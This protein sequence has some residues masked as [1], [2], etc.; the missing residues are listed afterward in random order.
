MQSH[1]MKASNSLKIALLLA[2]SV[3]LTVAQVKA[4]DDKSKGQMIDFLRKSRISSQ[5]GSTNSRGKQDDTPEG[6]KGGKTIQP[7]DTKDAEHSTQQIFRDVIRKW[8]QF[9]GVGKPLT[10]EQARHLNCTYTLMFD[11][12]GLCVQMKALDGYG[13]PTTDHRI[14][15][16]LTENSRGDYRVN[17]TIAEQMD[18]VCSWKF[19]YDDKKHLVYEEGYDAGG[20]LVYVMHLNHRENTAFGSYSDFYGSPLQLR[21]DTLQAPPTNF[22]VTYDNEGHDARLETF[23]NNGFPCKNLDGAYSWRRTYDAIG[24]KTSEASC[25]LMGHRTIDDFGNCGFSITYST[26]G[27]VKTY[28]YRDAQWNIMPLPDSISSNH[29]GVVTVKEEYDDYGRLIQ[30]TFYD[31]EQQET[32][33]KR[34]FNKIHYEYNPHGL[35]RWITYYDKH[36]N[37]FCKDSSAVARKHYEYDPQGRRIL[38]ENFNAYDEIVDGSDLY[39][40]KTW[41]YQDDVLTSE[42]RWWQWHGKIVQTYDDTIRVDPLTRHQIGVRSYPYDP[43]VVIYYERDEKGRQIFW[44][45]CDTLGQPFF[46][47]DYTYSTNI[48]TYEDLPG[49]KCRITDIY[50]SPDGRLALKSLEGQSYA[51][52]TILKDSIAQTSHFTEWNADS[53]IVSNYILHYTAPDLELM[54]YYVSLNPQGEPSR[55][56]NLNNNFI[57]KEVIRN[58]KGDIVAYVAYNEFDEPA[59][60][61]SGNGIYHIQLIKD[62]QRQNLD[63]DK[64]EITRNIK[65]NAPY[66]ISIICMN[67]K[68]QQLGLRD[69]D[70]ILSFGSWDW[71][72]E[73]PR[74]A[75]DELWR[76]SI[77]K[78]HKNKEL[79][80]I[81][82]HRDKDEIT[83]QL[84]T[85]QLPEGTT[86]DLGI[87]FQYIT[88]TPTELERFQQAAD[89]SGLSTP[90]GSETSST[91]AIIRTPTGYGRNCPMYAQ[92]WPT[93]LRSAYF[94][95]LLYGIEKDAQGN[96]KIKESWAFG[97]NAQKFNEIANEYDENNSMLWATTDLQTCNNQPITT[98]LAASTLW[99]Y[100]SKD[101]SQRLREMADSIRTIYDAQYNRQ[102]QEKLDNVQYALSEWVRNDRQQGDLQ[103]ADLMKAFSEAEHTFVV[104][105]REN[106]KKCLGIV[107][108][109]DDT[110]IF[111]AYNDD[112]N[113]PSDELKQLMLRANL[114]GFE[115]VAQ[116]HKVENVYMQLWVK[117]KR[118]KILQ[119]L[120]VRQIDQSYD[121]YYLP[122]G[123]NPEELE[124][125]CSYLQRE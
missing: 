44:Q 29:N 45:Y 66:A 8:G 4:D 16:Y 112:D 35:I 46:Y 101:E 118:K 26:D 96:I 21:S 17:N 105:N 94:P 22:C 100:V 20:S 34:G 40:R 30:E 31:E 70:Y 50:R 19:K 7:Q 65:W 63:I 119:M 82:F 14:S 72:T 125:I 88:L 73:K 121:L 24:R 5:T 122:N 36:G 83:S 104:R 78:V 116:R 111:Y 32:N 123:L 76:E 12:I 98:Y 117:K 6:M 54:D 103:P 86:V 57:K 124:E 75:W 107:P 108:T 38:Y 87:Y 81:R 71:R 69:G 1:I 10:A 84:L 53:V 114:S 106:L 51:L 89:N 109:P 47:R 68:A 48:T 85:V 15:S 52:R 90:E 62:D 91:T 80:L 11:Q 92:H 113:G 97:D 99:T 59:Y 28:T 39:A 33:N 58:H 37:L 77:R 13:H 61:E 102:E 110:S 64:K 18:N 42:R 79:N 43:D 74:D 56:G 9:V 55:W 95:L 41:N 2:I 115:L 67:E 27:K 93:T 25:D 60:V 23:D 49:H 3:L 120:F